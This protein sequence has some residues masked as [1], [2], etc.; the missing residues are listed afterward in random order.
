[1]KKIL[2]L[3]L[4]ILPYL[5]AAQSVGIG[6]TT[7]DNS[8]SLDIKNSTK[9]ILVPRTSTTSRTTIVAPAKGLM[10]FDTT[11]M[12]FWFH[13]GTDWVEAGRINAPNGNVY[14]G[15]EAGLSAHPDAVFNTGIG[16]RALSTM[17]ITGAGN[18]AVGFYA[19]TLNQAFHN[20]AL[21][22][23]ALSTNS[24]GFR[25]TALGASTLEFNT[26]GIENTAAGYNALS[27]NTTGNENVAIGSQAMQQSTTGGK[28]VAIG[29]MAMTSHTTGSENTAI[30]RQAMYS[31][32]TGYNNTAVGEAAMFQNSNGHDQTAVGDSAL[33]SYVAT[34]PTLDFPNTAVGAKALLKTQGGANNA[35]GFEALRNTTNGYNN[36]ALG[37]R[38]LAANTTG[39]DN[40]AIGHLAL[41]TNLSG[42][43]NIAI[44]SNALL[45]ETSSGGNVAIGYYA[46]EDITTSSQNVAIGTRALENTTT[47]GSNI[48]IGLNSLAS[49]NTGTSNI[50]IGGGT[51][52]G[53][54]SNGVILIG[55]NANTTGSSLTNATAIG[56]GAQVG[57]TG[58]LA[59]G[60]STASTQTRIGINNAVP[61]TDL[62]IIQQVDFGLDKSRGIR[63]Q[64]ST[65][66]NQWRTFIDPGNNYVFEY[67][68]GL[69]TYID[70]TTGAYVNPSDARLKKDILP[71]TG[72]LD[73]LLQLEAKTYHYTISESDRPVYGFL[74]QE[75]EKLFPEF[76]FTGQDNYKGIAYHN[77]SI[78]AVKAIQEQQQQIDE[79]KKENKEIRQLLEAVLKKLP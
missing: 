17:G 70:P 66:T 64:R 62:H 14:L 78:V 36:N 77:F 45:S 73:K 58:C 19:L 37:F 51:S 65:G 9:G 68:N 53:S 67:N 2:A 74:T 63:L 7:P 44:G 16:T 31:S 50:G 20:T 39:Y 76:V 1:M 49:N 10:L 42:I 18:T 52:T 8:A 38:A 35:V 41:S 23:S 57:C 26:T 3:S 27:T 56:T 34:A 79:L 13:T 21:G 32:H 69:Y 55:N 30:G 46:G 60:G 72:V 71:L 75:V 59:L 33:F 28:N 6:T 47:G 24:T 4:I 40:V 29:H 48:A 43:Q 11:T 22:Y 12:S 25:N 54:G 5:L 15:F 61:L